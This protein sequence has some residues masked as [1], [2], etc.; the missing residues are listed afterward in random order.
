MDQIQRWPVAKV[1]PFERNP[2]H[3]EGAVDACAASIAAFGFRFPILVDAEGVIIA[4]HTRLKAALKLGL[5]D[6]PVIVAAD[7][8]PDQVRALRIADNKVG[9]L[10][11]WNEDLL[12]GELEAIGAAIDM[13]LLGF[14]RGDLDRI[15]AGGYAER[16]VE[17]DDVPAVPAVATTKRGQLIRLGR[18]VLLCGD[19]ASTE[20]VDRLV[21]RSPIHLVHTDPPYNVAVQPRSKPKAKGE[22]KTERARDRVI[23]ND[24]H[25]PAEYERLVLAWFGQ[26]ARVLVPGGAVYAWGG[27]VS[28]E[29]YSLAFRRNNLH[30][31]QAIIWIKEHP[32]LSR[33][34]F[35]GNHE[36]C[37]YG[38]RLGSA[39]RFFG[40]ANV[41]DTWEVR[42][43]GKAPRGVKVGQGVRIKAGDAAIDVVPASAG[44]KGLA[45]VELGDDQPAI[46]HADAA[47]DVWR[48][49]KVSPQAMVHLTEKPVE[50]ARRAIEYSTLPGENV[51]DLFG[52]SG[53]TLI[54]AERTGRRA[55]LMELDPLY[56][57]VIIARWEAFAG[58]AAERIDG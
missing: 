43:G 18:H 44:R 13:T 21:A 16:G 11:E 32:T 51:L 31:A 17:P 30:L 10:A 5:A 24:D 34:D 53:M 47:S 56:C 14:T 33:R 29:P 41:P 1:R 26:M 8:K 12:R 37:F 36:W 46:V 3:N 45:E 20:D 58:K 35:M 50:L 4:G 48:V 49:K 40:P 39:H 52:G 15:L 25:S 2:R 27:Y 42:R 28:P 54:A 38:W 7:L 9:E 22:K 23:L 55:F 19:S 57:D 6:V